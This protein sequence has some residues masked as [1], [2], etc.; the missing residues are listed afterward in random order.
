[1]IVFALVTE[2]DFINVDA[3]GRRGLGSGKALALETS[4][5]E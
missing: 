5:E 2:V 3:E 4:A 1:M